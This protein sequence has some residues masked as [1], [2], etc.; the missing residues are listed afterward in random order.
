MPRKTCVEPSDELVMQY[1]KEILTSLNHSR[2]ERFQ[3]QFSRLNEQAV[4][5][6]VR[7]F[8]TLDYEELNKFFKFISIVDSS[9][10]W[11]VMRAAELVKWIDE[12]SI[13]LY[14]IFYHPLIV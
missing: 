12:G 1:M 6:Q 8:G 3:S 2:Y 7:D 4:L 9:H 5:Q 11:T 14:Q 10:P 13:N